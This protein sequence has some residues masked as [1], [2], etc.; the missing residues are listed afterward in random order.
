[1]PLEQVENG[2]EQKGAKPLGTIG[3]GIMFSSVVIAGMA[4]TK[5]IVPLFQGKSE[6][7]PKPVAAVAPEL[8][9]T[10]PA[11]LSALQGQDNILHV[12]F[13]VVG[14]VSG[15][16]ATSF[17]VEMIGDGLSVR[18]NDQ[19]F[20]I[21]EVTVD[22]EVFSCTW[23]EN[24]IAGSDV[25]ITSDDGLRIACPLGNVHVSEG[26]LGTIAVSGQKQ[27]HPTVNVPYKLKVEGKLG[28]VLR[29][30]GLKEEGTCTLAFDNITP[31]KALISS[32]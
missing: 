19:S 11:S 14:N 9:R 22:G 29:M 26:S 12:P 21:R 28:D 3:R 1:M 31:K 2:L 5:F 13:N 10:A 32:K 7:P 24:I 20:R 18:V 8:T 6:C 23:I 4:A 16:E 25:K 30:L 27:E 17:T 15:E